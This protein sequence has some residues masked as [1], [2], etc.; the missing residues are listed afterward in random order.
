MNELLLKLGYVILEKSRFIHNIM[1]EFLNHLLH[2]SLYDL[3][4]K[5]TKNV[6]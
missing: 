1:S 3:F 4:L 5:Q 2:L 6:D